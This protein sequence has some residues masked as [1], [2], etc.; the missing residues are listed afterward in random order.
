M[1]KCNG[2]LKTARL[3]PFRDECLRCLVPIDPTRQRWLTPPFKDGDCEKFK[4]VA[5]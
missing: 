4:A 1:E 2:I 3:C 5:Q